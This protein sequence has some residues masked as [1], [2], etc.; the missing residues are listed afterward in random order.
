[1]N[2]NVFSNDTCQGFGLN[3][4]HPKQPKDKQGKGSAEEHA[5]KF[6]MTKYFFFAQMVRHRDKNSPQNYATQGILPI[7]SKERIEWFS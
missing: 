6:E 2:F 5:S 4:N 7:E 3:Q 1:L